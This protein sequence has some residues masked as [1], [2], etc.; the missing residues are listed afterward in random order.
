MTDNTNQITE[1]A[2]TVASVADATG[3]VAGAIKWVAILGVVGVVGFGAYKGY[4]MV[5]NIG[6]AVI[7]AGAAV[8]DAGVDGVTEQIENA[9]ENVATVRESVGTAVGTAMEGVDT[10]ALAEHA[11]NAAQATD[12][13]ID[14]G[15]G[16]LQKRR[17][18]LGAALD[19][20]RD[21]TVT[22]VPDPVEAD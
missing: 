15:L 10:E 1:G 21:T 5:T 3:Q 18:Q 9:G 22:G 19:G 20:D 7:D 14:T 6:G 2:K 16:W 4:Q 13:A 12:S 17:D 8:V 11:G